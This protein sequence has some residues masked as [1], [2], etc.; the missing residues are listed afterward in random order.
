MRGLL[1]K[2]FKLLK[3]QKQFFAI[4]I[5]VGL[6]FMITY[7]SPSFVISY[8]TIMFSMFSIT[9]ITYDEFDNGGTY[10]FTLPFRRKE[11]VKEKY[12][13]GFLTLALGWAG[14]MVL[15]VVAGLV[16][17]TGLNFAEIGWTSAAAITLSVFF[18]SVAIPTEIKLG[19]EK[20]RLGLILVMAVFFLSCYLAV[21]AVNSQGSVSLTEMINKAMEA[22]EAVIIGGLCAAWI[23]AVGVSMAVSVRFINRKEF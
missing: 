18:L 15:A 4:I 11:Y 6:A 17:G 22:N 21:K 3:N 12:L 19:A 20:G 2:D 16:R 7:S 1:I 23:A 8:I 10:L 13:F 14:A 5:F 9:T